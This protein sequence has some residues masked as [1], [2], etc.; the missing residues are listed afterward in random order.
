M[1]PAADGAELIARRLLSNR[2]CGLRLPRR[3]IKQ[4]VIDARFAL[5]P[6]AEGNIAHHIVHDRLDLRRDL[7]A[8]SRP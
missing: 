4:F 6:D 1:I 8:S 2:R 5:A 3:I 7:F